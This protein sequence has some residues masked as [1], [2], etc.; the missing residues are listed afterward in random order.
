MEPLSASILIAIGVGLIILEMFVFSFYLIWLGIGLLIVG[1]VSYFYIFDSVYIQLAL[2]GVI[3][4]ALLLL[5]KDKLKQTLFKDTPKHKDE[6]LEDID[7][8]SEAIVKEGM[9]FYKGTFWE[10][11]GD[12]TEL[13]EGTKVTVKKIVGNK[14]KI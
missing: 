6:F 8:K 2:G 4:V 5:F 13:Q 3:S 10:V 7:S 11:D 12:I 1:F 14:I 9:L